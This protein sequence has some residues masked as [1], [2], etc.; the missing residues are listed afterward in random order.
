MIDTEL[1]QVEAERLRA[2][3]ER[4]RAE[5]LRLS[6]ELA[7]DDLTGLYNARHLRETLEECLDEMIA[8]NRVPALLFIDVDRFKDINEGHGHAA[9][10]KILRQVGRLLMNLIRVEDT[11]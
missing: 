11:A 6:R 8:Q 1:A 9:A 4:L 10:G 2:E 7:I 5:V 3:N